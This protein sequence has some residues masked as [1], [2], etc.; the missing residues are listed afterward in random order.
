MEQHCEVLL[1][2][3][4]VRIDKLLANRNYGSRKDVKSLIKSK[5]VYVNNQLVTKTDFKI[6]EGDLIAIDE[7]EWVYN[8]YEYLVLHKPSG[9]VSANKD[10]LHP[11]VFDYIPEDFV[12]DFHIVGR[13]DVDTE[14]L[15]IITNDGKF[16]HQVISPNNKVGK[17]YEVH[18]AKCI[19]DDYIDKFKDGIIIDDDY[20]CMSAKLEIVDKQKCLLTIYEGKFHQVKKMFL[21]LDNEVTYL[22]RLSIGNLQL[23]TLPVGEYRMM[24]KEQMYNLCISK[25]N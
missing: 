17:T 5:V 14:G 1:G 16:T 20:Q 25:E 15:I 23:G 12:K 10:N 3:L 7:L 8:Q 24:T 9:C 11:T 18:L 22:K 13:L 2:G 4:N 21:A 6:N 19:E